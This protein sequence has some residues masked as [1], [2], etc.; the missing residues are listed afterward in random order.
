M[1]KVRDRDD[2]TLRGLAALIREERRVNGD[3]PKSRFVLAYFRIAQFAQ[4][5]RSENHLLGPFAAIVIWSY[6]LIVCWLLGVELPEG[7]V[8]GRRLRLHHAYGLVVNNGSIIG[9]DVVLRHGV[10]IGNNGR[11]TE[12][13][14]LQDGVDIGA[15]A[16]VIGG[17]KIGPGARIG[18]NAVVVNDVPAY[19]TVVGV[20]A[21]VVQSDRDESK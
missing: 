8:V 21:K 12:A 4:L 13:P 2:M 11:T 1:S 5:R 17:I 7:T 19:A 6:R 9:D 18:A 14:H 15:G 16:V 3:D 10:T 20:P